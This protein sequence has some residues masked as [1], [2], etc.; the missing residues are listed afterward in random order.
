MPENEVS[1]QAQEPQF[2]A[3][4]GIDW[5]DQKHAWC[6]QVTGSRQRESGELEHK[7]ETVEA[8]VAQLCQRFGER[9][10]AIAVEQV[11]GAL[12]YM[13]AKYKCLHLYPVPSTMAASMRKALHP[14]GA[15]DD[16]R[17]ADLL[18]DFLLKHRDKLHRL[19]PDNEATRRV[20]NLVEERRNLVDEKT[21]QI[22]RL[23]S[24]IK[25]YFPQMLD[26]FEDLDTELVCGLLERWPTLE[27]LQKA[28]PEELRTFFHQHHCRKEEL[29]EHR[30]QGI[31]QARPAIQ[32]RPVI[33]AK[34]AV[35][36]VT[37][38]LIR[39]LRVAIA[40]LDGKIAEAAAA[41]PDFFIFASLPGAGEV[42]APR[43]LAAFGSQRDRYGSAN[44]VQIYS[45]I[46]PV[47]EASGKMKWVHFRRACP[48]FLRQSF[49]EW[50][51]H[52]MV[53]S[54]WAR[55]YYQQQRK[56]G[57]GH[58]AAVRAL[59]FKWIRIVFRCWKDRVAYDEKKYLATLAKRGSPLS[60][61]LVIPTGAT[62]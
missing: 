50:A 26:W 1:Q 37:V 55:A 52:S 44:E 34:R 42:M 3:F 51:G 43:L 45:G 5:A 33:E 15:K 36:K 56:Q 47:L 11:K 9:P 14:S 53:K 40:E 6:L 4:V 13:L 16:P 7:V 35:V 29:I 17:D 59:A 60:A 21:A 25:I 30:I 23:T 20:Q 61:L 27:E 32:D 49:H 24:N 48:K 18:L 62:L 10:I 12:V 57:Q 31:G 58:H 39:S 54:V 38:Q 41:H 28:S 22:N 2:A 19:A 46:A 8:W